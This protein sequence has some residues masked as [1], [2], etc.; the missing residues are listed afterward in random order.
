LKFPQVVYKLKDSSKVTDRD[1]KFIQGTKAELVAL[2][3]T[4]DSDF[5]DPKFLA[6][7]KNT[8]NLEISYLPEDVSIFENSRASEL[9]IS[10]DIQL[11]GDLFKYFKQVKQVTVTGDFNMKFISL[12]RSSVSELR[13]VENKGSCT[14][15]MKSI[16]HLK[17]YLQN[18][19]IEGNN[20]LS[21]I[22][23]TSIGEF[24]KLKKVSFESK[25]MKF[26]ALLP[27]NIEY[28]KILPSSKTFSSPLSIESYKIT[29]VGTGE[30]LENFFDKIEVTSLKYELVRDVDLMGFYIS[31]QIFSKISGDKLKEF[32]ILVDI[33]DSVTLSLDKMQL[34]FGKRV[35]NPA[36][37]KSLEKLKISG[38]ETYINNKLSEAIKQFPKLEWIDYSSFSMIQGKLTEEELGYRASKFLTNY[39]ITKVGGVGGLLSEGCRYVFRNKYLVVF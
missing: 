13:I 3:I 14:F 10:T 4:E 11:M 29:I 9:S 6:C 20:S 30:V 21:E 12:I 36:K 39:E 31:S 8:R 38:G 2:K 25:D 26:P 7:L 5:A 16:F 17:D 28:L 35:L 18:I 23:A 33:S 22:E 19:K 24:K 32:D 34:F 37:L 27:R 15:Y 1:W